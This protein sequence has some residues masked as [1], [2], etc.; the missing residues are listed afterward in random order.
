MG[1]S[2]ELCRDET[3]CTSDLS[4]LATITLGLLQ[5]T[6]G[7]SKFSLRTNEQ[8]RSRSDYASK[9]CR[10]AYTNPSARGMPALHREDNPRQACMVFCK[11]PSSRKARL[12]SV[13]QR[14][15]ARNRWQSLVDKVR[16]QGGDE[17]DAYFPDGTWCHRDFES[18]TDYFCFD[19]KCQAES[20][21]MEKDEPKEDLFANVGNLR[22]RLL[23]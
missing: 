9:K 23:F 19:R 6:K 12:T 11:V 7:N 22:S 4:E 16:R 3:T 14:P 17:G 18:G 13:W 1:V 10:T 8:R 21:L 2:H 15:R 20:R 5:F